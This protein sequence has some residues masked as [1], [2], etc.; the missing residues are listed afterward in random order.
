MRP[1]P[2]EYHAPATLDEAAALLARY[3]EAAS[4][5]AG[6]QS[7]VPA[8]AARLARPSHV[9]DLNWTHGTRRPSVVA[10]RLAIPPL[11]RHEDFATPVVDGPLGAIL[12]ELS[13]HIGSLSVRTRGTFCG[14]IANADPASEWCLAAV[15]LGAEVTARSRNRGVRQI[16][17][18]RFFD[19]TMATVLKDDELVSAVQIPLLAGNTRHG[20]AKLGPN[21]ADYGAA[22]A[23][24]VFRQHSAIM[25]DVRIG[26]GAVTDVPRRASL[27]EALLERRAPSLRLFRLAAEAA[28]SQLLPRS[29]GDEAA[30]HRSDL[31]RVAVRQALEETLL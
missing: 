28:A 31:A 21:A 22:T 24:A 13:R 19:T 9:I 7:L 20:F 18:E 6:G 12:A 15:V 27:A 30:A 2:F 8:M 14:A 3:G 4:V 10:G 26:L 1:A 5:L 23:L 16:R 25:T 11:M 29:D 17:A